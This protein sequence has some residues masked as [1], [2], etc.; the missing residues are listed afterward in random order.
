[1]NETDS[2]AVTPSLAERVISAMHEVKLE[3]AKMS[4]LQPQVADHE[5]RLR[6]LERRAWALAGA[7]S[8]AG[9]LLS[10]PVQTLFK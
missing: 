8:V 7:A 4:G 9:A 3:L 6:A 2:D 10:E 5:A 1:M